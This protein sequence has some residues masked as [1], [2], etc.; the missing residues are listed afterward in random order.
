MDTTT[1]KKVMDIPASDRQA[2]EHLLGTPLEPQ[3]RVM[4]FTYTP[5][6]LPMD[7]ARAT[8]RSQIERMIAT[9]QQLAINEGITA[10]EADAAIDEAMKSA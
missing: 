7:E 3:Q 5:G 2:L 4:I 6:Q 9:N 10:E 8:A 1:T